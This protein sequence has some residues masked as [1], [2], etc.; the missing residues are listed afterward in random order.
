MDDIPEL[1]LVKKL[2]NIL[3]KKL[4]FTEEE[5]EEEKKIIIILENEIKKVFNE[6]KGHDFHLLIESLNSLY[7]DI[8]NCRFEYFVRDYSA[9]YYELEAIEES[10]EAFTAAFQGNLEK[11]KEF[12][13]KYNFYKEKSGPIYQNTLLYSAAR[14]GH[15]HIVRYLIEDR[16]CDVNIQNLRDKSTALHVASYYN[17]IEVVKYLLKKGAN[18]SLINKYGETPITN[19]SQNDTK[20]IYQ[21]EL[22][23]TWQ[24]QP[25][26][27]DDWFDFSEDENE[28]LNNALQKNQSSIRFEIRAILYEI[29]LKNFTRSGKNLSTESMAFVRN[30]QYPPNE[31]LQN[32]SV[33]WQWQENNTRRWHIF[34]PQATNKLNK[35]SLQKSPCISILETESS[36]EFDI[37]LKLFEWKSKKI[38]QKGS[39]RWIPFISNENSNLDSEFFNEEE[40]EEENVDET[41]IILENKKKIEREE[42]RKNDEKILKNIISIKNLT[43]KS[44]PLPLEEK[45]IDLNDLTPKGEPIYTE[46]EGNNLHIIGTEEQIKEVIQKLENKTIKND[47]QSQKENENQEINN[48]N[49]GDDKNFI[50]PYGYTPSDIPTTKIFRKEF[51][52]SENCILLTNI[53]ALKKYI[54]EK[55]KQNKFS[56]TTLGHKDDQYIT[57][58]IEGSPEHIE[59]IT[60]VMN[61]I[62]KL[63]KLIENGLKKFENKLKQ[64]IYQMNMNFSKIPYKSF[65]KSLWIDYIKSLQLIIDEILL[66]E[67]KKHKKNLKKKSK[68]LLISVIEN[69]NNWNQEIFNFTEI[70][71][72]NNSLKNNF[73][74]LT[75]RAFQSLIEKKKKDAIDIL[76][77]ASKESITALNDNL[78]S[79]EN[80]VK[81]ELQSSN[82]NNDKWKIFIELLQKTSIF[83]QAFKL[84]LPLFEQSR[85]FLDQLKKNTIICIHTGTGSGKSTLLPVLLFADGYKSIVVTQPRRLPCTLISKRVEETFGEGISGWAVS[86]KEENSTN[87]VLYVTDGLLKEKLFFE[88]PKYDIIVL[89]EI[90]ERGINMDTCI[91]LL[92]NLFIKNPQLKLKI[93]LSSATLD[94]IIKNFFENV[95]SLKGKILDFDIPVKNVF[96]VNIHKEI[97]ANPI[98][99]VIELYKKKEREEQILCFMPSVKDVR[100]ASQLFSELT[101]GSKAYSLYA[102]QSPNQQKN[103]L[104]HGSVFFSTNIAET[105]LT[106]PHLRYVVDTGK[107]N[108]SVLD[109]EKKWNKLKEILAP[110]STIQQRKGRL[111]RTMPGDYYQLYDDSQQND[112]Y[113]IPEIQKIDLLDFYFNL[114][115]SGIPNLILPTP[116]NSNSI[117][118]AKKQLEKLEITDSTGT[119]LTDLGKEISRLPIVG[120][121]RIMKAIYSALTKY[122]CG[123]T[124]IELA[125]ILMSMSVNVSSLLRSIPKILQ[126]SN[127]DF[128]TLL[129]VFHEIWNLKESFDTSNGK[130]FFDVRKACSGL[131]VTM[132]IEILTKAIRRYELLQNAFLKLPK[133]RNSSQISAKNWESVACSLL[134]GF[135]D[136]IFINLGELQGQKQYYLWIKEDC[137]KKPIKVLMDP[138]STL[139]RNINQDQIPFVIAK[140][141]FSSAHVRDEHLGSICVL[142]EIKPEWITFEVRDRKINITITEENNVQVQQTIKSFCQK[143][144]SLKFTINNQKIN[145]SGPAGPLFLLEKE[146]RKTLI[147]I[148]SIPL[149]DNNDNDDTKEKM[150]NVMRMA[151]IFFPLNWRW[152]N[153]Q[154]IKIDIKS[155]KL[156]IEVTGREKQ[157]GKVKEEFMSFKGWLKT[158]NVLRHPN[159]GVSPRVL[160]PEA[161]DPEIEKRINF[162]TDSRRSLL[163]IWEHSVGPKSN[164]ETRMATVAWIAVCLFECRIEGGFV[165]D[166][167]VGGYTSRPSTGNSKQWLSKDKDGIPRLDD[168]LVPADLDFQLPSHKYFD[169]N[170]FLDSLHKYHIKVDEIIRQSWRYVLLFD[171]DS[172]PFTADLIEPH[173]VATHDMIDFDVSNLYCLKD[174]TRELGMRVDITDPPAS[175]QLEQIVDNI[176]NK[177]FNILR[178]INAKMEQRIKKMEK[179]GWKLQLTIPIAPNKGPKFGATLAIVPVDDP[180]YKTLKQ[181]FQKIKGN[182]LKIELISNYTLEKL[183]EAMK[184]QIE[185]ENNNNANERMLFHGT[186]SEGAKGIEDNGFDDRFFNSSGAW[187]HGAYF[188]DDVR[189]SHNYTDN[190]TSTRVIFW[191]KVLLGNQEILNQP[192]QSLVS[193]SKGYHSVKGTA[194]T[195]SEYIVYRYGQAKPYMKIS[196]SV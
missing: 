158:C 42:T 66:E 171:S 186:K 65:I 196:Y 2:K 166:W 78:K 24:Y 62:Y 116:P 142:G 132:G 162:I 164:R 151:N 61:R 83:I 12:L 82:N 169:I 31:L 152:Q 187:G 43:M 159:S 154:Q 98:T 115:K 101:G 122:N 27:T 10:Y 17:H 39:I 81:E 133:Y 177:K 19:S 76:K 84:N 8:K 55:D 9:F 182:I 165:R 118:L 72:Q 88:I 46:K 6:N 100:E 136:Q 102:Q 156:E 21:Q 29:N 94:P 153:T 155:N 120:N 108:I 18:C 77:N 148:E 44:I 121:V 113:P 106:F 90:H 37:D 89:D 53:K 167:I 146:I 28:R 87:P 119:N 67:V 70:S 34:N 193:P 57:L 168:F 63:E 128:E 26:D 13:I 35:A 163:D 14:N 1:K 38:N 184:L 105:S 144:P 178:S 181:E 5:I 191:V 85:K 111:G 16:N 125:S 96:H 41:D 110:K 145:L 195:Y 11:V 64:F 172:V 73:N 189:K 33:Q 161:R 134:S 23:I 188:A 114:L 175:I 93:I 95:N 194:F 97:G 86:G 32:F 173:I 157:I 170:R 130:K 30:R 103:F 112:D 131:G 48:E 126:S 109:Q 185:K 3:S 139:S 36:S 74:N 141:I 50:E 22:I 124:M 137:N 58:E 80:L 56:I 59:E 54:E 51:E 160:K 45:D 91:A 60:K 150:K 149:I 99:K 7:F 127:G 140:D 75:F 47:I 192:N 174:F 138:N 92:A 129:K 104:K 190:K 143:Y 15:L 117:N 176:K 68:E 52:I 40:N 147:K 107:I 20:F 123:R 135:Q 79:I 179:R 49:T 180:A 25:Q 71:I 183:Y 4:I 69:K